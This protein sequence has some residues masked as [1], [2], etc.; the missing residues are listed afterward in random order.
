VTDSVSLPVAMRSD[1]SAFFETSFLELR[2]GTAFESNW[3]IDALC[4]TARQ[5]ADG[6]KKRLA[7]CIPPRHLKSTIGSVALPAW[8]LGHNPTAK[9]IC[10]S[11]G[12]DLAKDF[13]NQTR[14]LMTSASYARAFPDVQLEKSTDLHLRTVQGGERYATTIGGPI[15]G[16]GADYIIVDDPMKLQEI[17][18]E[19]RRHDVANWTFNLSTRLNDPNTGR[20]LVIAQR[21]HQ[22]DVIGRIQDKGGWDILSLPLVATQDETYERGPGVFYHRKAGEYLH[23]SRIGPAVAAELSRDLGRQSF[24]A[25]YQ[26]SP[27]P[28]GS[29]FIDLTWFKRFDAPPEAFEH[30]FFSVDVATIAEAG[31]YSVCTHDGS[32]DIR[33]FHTS[34][35]YR[36]SR[37]SAHPLRE[38]RRQDMRT[39]CPPS[40]TGWLEQ[41]A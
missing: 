17:E 32:G 36:H 9:I 11:Y 7:I 30:I 18:S 40:R 27:L 31:D 20:I 3:H 14:N 22:D 19:S 8:I 24:A 28:A 21:L 13:S 12:E 38:T 23:P 4:W 16:K 41:L 39:A 33:R 10:V 26:Q 34:G 1:F 35:G 15:T 2:P 29:G 6:K 37:I 25:Q 5:F